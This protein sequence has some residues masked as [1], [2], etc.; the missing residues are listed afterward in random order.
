MGQVAE[1]MAQFVLPHI[2]VRLYLPDNK[3]GSSFFLIKPARPVAR[4]QWAFAYASRIRAYRIQLRYLKETYFSD[5]GYT[6][7]TCTHIPMVRLDIN[8][9]AIVRSSFSVD[10]CGRRTFARTSPLS[11]CTFERQRLLEIKLL[12]VQ[13][14]SRQG[15]LIFNM[16]LI[17]R[18][19]RSGDS[20]GN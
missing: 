1:L 7:Y 6:H 20:G 5:S 4:P 11:D 18:Q 16:P 14:G 19:E 2:C 3:V 12:S 17:H 13:N 10:S 8:A 9:R 15:I